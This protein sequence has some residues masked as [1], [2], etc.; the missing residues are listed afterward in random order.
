[1]RA[2]YD[3]QVLALERCGLDVISVRFGRPP[4]FDFFAGQWM[5]LTLV[6]GGHRLTETFTICSAPGDGYLE[7]T[8]RISGSAFKHA[9][10]A[11]AEGDRVTVSGP[12]GRFALPDDPRPVFLVGGVGITPV[13]SMLRDAC[14]RGRVFEDAVV[15]Y[16]NRDDSCVPF[17]AEIDAMSGCGVRTV[18][19]YESPPT[20]WAGETGLITAETVR[21]H[22]A[23]APG[24]RTFIVAG[25]PLMVEAMEVVLDDL[26]V[27]SEHRLVE[28]FSSM[29]PH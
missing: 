28:R 20:G 21:R 22:L 13:R 15:F 9:L 11:L 5:Q 12:G 18:L 10:E 1:M 2:E 6:A 25:P 26:G 4:G 3:V 14:A 16:G 23:G 27:R 29:R 17:A 24:D 7:I 8:T 19:C